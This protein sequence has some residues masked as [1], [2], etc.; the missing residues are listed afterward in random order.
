M[1][2]GDHA[3]G[4]SASGAG[5]TAA[6][7]GGGASAGGMAGAGAAGGAGKLTGTPI[8][9]VGGYGAN[10]PVRAYNI[11]KA[12]GALTQRGG[13]FDA[14]AD[15]SYLT[16]DPSRSHLYAA[17][18][19][20]GQEGGITALA[21]DE[22]GAL[23]KLNHRTGSDKGFTYVAVAPGGKFVLGASYNGGSVSVF[24]L[25]AD[26]AIDPEVDSADFGANSQAHAV[27]FDKTGSYVLV[28][29]K[30][31]NQIQQLVL[32]Q[33]G[34]LTA[35]TPPNV[36]SAA[37]AGP[38]HIAVHPSG[39]LA[40]VVNEQSS[41]LTPYQLSADGKL[42]AGSSISTLPL[43]F[44]GESKGA[45]V[46]LSPDGRFVYA[47]NRGH[48]SIAVFS[49]DQSTG[50]LTLVEHESTRGRTPRD[51]DVDPNGD[52]LIVANQDSASL[53]VY[54][55]EADGAISPLGS[56]TPSAPMPSAVQIHYVP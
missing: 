8:V 48:D 36:A 35:N 47:S 53:S 20:D 22:S 16:L 40:F 12:T 5:G 51:F 39:K 4:G 46:E 21:I 1:S 25:T 3:S 14:G 52:V 49:V 43:D 50:S 54:K 30:G 38:R 55:I 42:T 26:G 29:T 34:M 31:A 28:P 18:E 33:D 27:G 56:P 15:P 37:G 13:D 19:N 23:K 17:N 6:G 45:H 41:T 9:Y 11:D 7:Q 44:N 24:P 2:G 10:Y 32:G